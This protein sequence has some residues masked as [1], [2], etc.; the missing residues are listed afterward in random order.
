MKFPEL[1]PQEWFVE[2]VYQ[3]VK[4]DESPQCSI[5]QFLPLACIN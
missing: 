2:S 1:L 3:A 4:L 5:A